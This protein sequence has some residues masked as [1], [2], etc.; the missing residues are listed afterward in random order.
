MVRRGWRVVSRSGEEL[1]EVREV[2][3]DHDAGIFNGLLVEKGLL[4]GTEY[5][6]AEQVAEITE[7]E[8]CV[9]R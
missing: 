6:P 1:G 7:G 8:I 9:D 2:M 4:K 3:A 5:V